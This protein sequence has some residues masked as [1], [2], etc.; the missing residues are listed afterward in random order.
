MST[1]LFSIDAA[2]P[3]EFLQHCVCVCVLLGF[4]ASTGLLFF[5]L[6]DST[7]PQLLS[8]IHPWGLG[9]WGGLIDAF[10][11]WLGGAGGLI[12]AICDRIGGSGEFIDEVT[13]GRGLGVTH[14]LL[15]KTC[16]LM[17]SRNHCSFF[18]SSEGVCTVTDN[19]S[20]NGVWVNG[21]RLEPLRPCELVEG[22]VVQLGVPVEQQERA[23]YEYR[24]V[25]RSP[26][27]PGTGSG[28]K[29]KLGCEDS[30]TGVPQRAEGS[31]K[32]QRLG[33]NTHRP[34]TVQH[35]VAASAQSREDT[36][37]PGTSS[38]P[39]TSTCTNICHGD[40]DRDPES[41][42]RHQEQGLPTDREQTHGDQDQELS[43]DWEQT[44]G[45]CDQ[46][47]PVDR[48]PTLGDQ[49]QGRRCLITQEPTDGDQEQRCLTNEQQPQ[50]GVGVDV[51]ETRISEVLENELQCIICSEYFIQAVT[52]G[53][54]H[55]FCR[56]CIREWGRRRAECPICRQPIEW[57]TPSVVLDS[58]IER[59][60]S[61]L[62]EAAR[63]QRQ[64][65]LQARI[66]LLADGGR[67]PSGEGDLG[68][69]RP[70]LPPDSPPP[71]ILE[72]TESRSTGSRDQ[73]THL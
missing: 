18:L 64:Q 56:L 51:A 46:K 67:G 61:G 72:N 1:V 59:M 16:P 40:Q 20:L 19:Q 10:G 11:E 17:I 63:R 49:E 21:V 52:L 33:E 70:A 30:P 66:V 50:V 35:R 13:V 9:P 71:L 12:D 8:P 47:L 32:L 28:A 31:S 24:L 27:T 45:H 44:Q 2:E 4:P 7:C 3:T 29:R 42:H 65:L 26:G 37:Q 14:R 36:A 6:K 57:Q 48:D 58:C 68:G 38:Q 34:N 43:T 53:C 23:E 73:Q 41:T 22:D 5:L 69:E 54:S 15:A 39:P 60:V 25:R 62:G 55:S